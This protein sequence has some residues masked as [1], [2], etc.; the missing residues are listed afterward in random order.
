[1][2]LQHESL[3]QWFEAFLVD[4]LVPDDGGP[5]ENAELLWILIIVL[6]IL[7][8]GVHATY[9]LVYAAETLINA[10]NGRGEIFPKETVNLKNGLIL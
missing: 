5:S 2:K 9:E 7:N 1:M 4:L 8:L 3:A 10:H 6:I